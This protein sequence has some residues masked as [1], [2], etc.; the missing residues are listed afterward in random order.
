MEFGNFDHINNDEFDDSMNLREVLEKYLIHWKWFILSTIVFIGL[1]YYYVRK[2]MPKYLVSST[3][4]V[5]EKEKGS[6]VNNLES[7]ENLGIF[8]SNDNSVE[9]EIYILTSRRL[10]KKVV[11]ELKLNIRYFIENN[12][13]NLEYYPNFPVILEFPKDS[14]EKGAESERSL[15]TNYSFKINVINNLKF[16]YFD[17]DENS[18]GVKEFG[19]E[20]NTDFGKIAIKLNDAWES[21]IT[22]KNIIV[23]VNSLDVMVDYFKNKLTIEPLDEKSRVVSISARE[24]VKRKGIAVINNLIEQYNADAVEDKNQVYKK[25]TEFLNDR[26]LLITSELNVIE[27]TVE[28][29]KTSKGLIDTKAG[30]NIYLASSSTNENE[31]INANTQL[32]LI[33]FMY[34]ELNNNDPSGLLPANI[35][36]SNPSIVNLIGEYNDLVL[37]RNRI[38]KSSTAINPLIISINSELSVLKGN[39][40]SSLNSV[41]STLKIQIDALT[42]QSGRISSRIASVP[43]NEKEFKDIIRQQETKNAVYLF[44]LQKREESI[45]SNAI[46]INKARVVD[47][48]YTNGIPVSPNPS[49]TY[50]AAIL[51]GMLLPAGFIF[52]KNILDTKVHDEKDI[53]KLNIPYLGDVPLVS[54]KKDL[55]I[56]EYDDSNLAESLRYLRTNINFML[57]SKEMGKTVFVTSTQSKEG[58]TFLA[59]NLAYSL[60]ISGKKTLLLAMDLR[61][62]KI[63]KYLGRN[64]SKGV[65]NFIK[66]DYLAIDDILEKDTKFDNLHIISSGDI[67]PNPVELLMNKKIIELFDYLK[68][69][70]EYIIVD[71]APVGMVTDTIQISKYAD[72]TMY[73]IQADHLDKRMLHIP[74][75]LFKENKLHNMALLLNG[76]DHGKGT[77]GYGYGYGNKKKK[78]WFGKV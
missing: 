9:N 40:I 39:I 74:K 77:Y 63:T 20:F 60:A 71:T 28:Q 30:A 75:T 41:E 31:L 70:Y 65:T 38:L 69:N 42:M 58:K 21:D 55:Y 3:I 1:A 47:S 12:P 61:A 6:S 11:T 78:S 35:G 50:L 13:Y 72:L 51:M 26:I 25:T 57:D 48:A 34:S 32:K 5:K 56:S 15:N 8:G 45:L 54:A 73:V 23:R 33:E 22:G 16:E 2:E 44:L 36:L 43:R 7:F 14:L 46:T 17:M 52:I 68:E 4:L 24:T 37:Q 19:K 62:P 27:S 59:I 49:V 10:M 53:K 18:K 76:T 29:F 66:N 67:P 64:K